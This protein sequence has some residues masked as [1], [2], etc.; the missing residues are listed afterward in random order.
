M[1]ES[2]SYYNEKKKQYE[3]KSTK[4]KRQQVHQYQTKKV[5]VME[6]RKDEILLRKTGS[7]HRDTTKGKVLRNGYLFCIVEKYPKRKKIQTEMILIKKTKGK[8]KKS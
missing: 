7:I 4:T 5:E 2:V 1:D 3:H 6:Q 8:G